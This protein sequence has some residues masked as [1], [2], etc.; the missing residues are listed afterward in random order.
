MGVIRKV[1]KLR[2]QKN[3]DKIRICD[4]SDRHL[5]NTLNRIDTMN[6]IDTMNKSDNNKLALYFYSFHEDL[7]KEFLRRKLT[8]I[9]E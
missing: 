4:M 1:T 3:V 5:I 8:F 9:K 2:K 6:L 7:E